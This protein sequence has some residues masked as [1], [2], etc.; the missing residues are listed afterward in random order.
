MPAMTQPA[1]RLLDDDAIVLRRTG[2]RFPVELRPTGFSAGEPSTWPEADGRLE[3]FEGRLL[4]MPPCAD[5]QQDVAVDVVH[6]LRTWSEAHSSFV[7]GANEAGMKLGADIRAADAAVWL[8]SEVGPSVG[9][10]RHVPP[11]LAVEVAGQDEDERVLREKA[12]WYLGQG[13][14]VVWLVIPESRSVLVLGK[15]GELQYRVGE[16]LAEHPRMPGLSPQV[17]QFFLQI[18]RASASHE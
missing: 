6:L 14:S 16:R 9:R 15:G 12:A 8:R 13:V 10:L 1:V 17:S 2:V 5:V 3:W 11:L 4:Y 7:V 18:D